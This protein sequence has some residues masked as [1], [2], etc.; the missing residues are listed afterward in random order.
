M[1]QPTVNLQIRGFELNDLETRRIDRQIRG[2]IGRLP[3]GRVTPNVDL[4]LDWHPIQRRVHTRLRVRHAPIGGRLVADASAR[5]ADQSVRMATERVERQ[6][7]RRQSARRGEPGYRSVRTRR[8]ARSDVDLGQLVEQQP[9]AG[10]DHTDAVEDKYMAKR[11][12]V[13]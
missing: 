5:T 4:R 7:K 11:P 8:R 2:L 6:L 9:L 12:G 10:T 13:S 3:D 1:S